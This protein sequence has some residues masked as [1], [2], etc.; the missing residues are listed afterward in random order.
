MTR[1][2]KEWSE[3]EIDKY[4]SGG[5]QPGSPV[6][7]AA[8]MELLMRAT[9]RVSEDVRKFD[10]SSTKLAKRMLW[11]TVAIGALAVAQVVVGVLGHVGR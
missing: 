10:R 5:A 8:H 7:D 3:A 9:V 2:P 11:L 4:L 6:Y 1:N